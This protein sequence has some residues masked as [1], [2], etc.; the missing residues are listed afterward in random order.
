M[1]KMHFEWAARELAEKKYKY[2][3]ILN[4]MP[5]YNENTLREKILLHRQVKGNQKLINTEWISVPQRL[6]EFILAQ[7][8]IDARNK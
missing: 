1:T 2:T 8:G 6:W 5:D 3:V 4:W 7:S